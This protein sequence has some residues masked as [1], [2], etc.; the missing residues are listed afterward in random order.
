MKQRK[1]Q[2]PRI[3]KKPNRWLEFLLTFILLSCLSGSQALISNE[4]NPISF[5]SVGQIWAYGSYWMMVALIISLVSA[6]IRRR[7]YEK[8][9]QKL[10]KAAR[11]VASGD[12]SVYVDNEHNGIKKDYI[13]VLFEDFNKMIKELG[14][15]ETL[16]N[17]FIANVSH[18]LKTPL[19]TIQNYATA[20]QDDSLSTETKKE[21]TNTI[22]GASGKL[23][24]LISNILKLNKMENDSIKPM[25]APF[26]VC[27]QL[28]DCILSFESIWERKGIMF[29]ADIED[30]AVIIADEGLLEIVWNNILSNAF[31]YTPVG[32]TVFLRQTSTEKTISVSITDS[33]CGMSSDTVNHIFEKFYQGETS[34][35]EDG[36]GLGLALAAKAVNLCNGDI[37]VESELEKGSVFTVTLYIS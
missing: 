10:S 20:L 23:S 32:G 22:I 37:T 8:P 13:D 19:A 25:P 31:K 24:V 21:Y 7:R 11:Q 29:D 4:Y 35:S 3:T 6:A 34:H 17:D 14:S 5:V 30:R 9:M 28:C 12:F 27:R 26:D 1:E 16:K 33:G 18:E 36:N 15:T 2:D